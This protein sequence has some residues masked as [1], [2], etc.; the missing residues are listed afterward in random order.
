MVEIFRENKSSSGYKLPR[1]QGVLLEFSA[2]P[3]AILQ[4]QA[5]AIVAKG[6]IIPILPSSPLFHSIHGG[7]NAIKDVLVRELNI[8]SQ[9]PQGGFP[10]PPGE[11]E[12]A[13]SDSQRR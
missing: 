12:A 5:M 11:W 13:S 4:Q 3:L 10:V 1:T 9:G 6:Q 7:E 8:G 2:I